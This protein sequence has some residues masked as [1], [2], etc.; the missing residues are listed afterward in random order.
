[1]VMDGWLIINK[2]SIYL[3]IFNKTLLLVIEK[4]SPFKISKFVY[5]K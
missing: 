1:M 2:P 3:L 4:N 5:N